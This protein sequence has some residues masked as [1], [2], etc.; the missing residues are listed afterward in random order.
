[1][2]RKIIQIDE[3]LCNGCGA[4]THVCAEAALEIV[5]GK[6]K[7]VRDFF[8][9]GMGACLD[10]CPVDA[11]KVVEKDTDAYDVEKTAEHVR[12]ARGEEAVK[13]VHGYQAEDE[14]E[15][16]GAPMACGCSGSMMRDFSDTPPPSPNN[17]EQTSAVS[18]LRQWPVQLH[19]VS[20]AAPYFK[21]ADLLISADCVPFA[22]ANFHNKFLKNKK[23]IMFCPKLDSGQE[24]YVEKL[25][26]LFQ[27][28]NIRSVTL[29]RMEV[30]C[31]GGVEYLVT[32][33]IKRAGVNVIIKDYTISIRGEVV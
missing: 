27:T 26:E 13:N 32:E 31:C 20:P 30:P 18:E 11:L 29:V 10:V 14:K 15:I 22:Y 4:C 12:K 8:C 25:T 23:L 2:K 7:L 6:A 28:Q 24:E 17:I 5:N 1:M 21:D 33:A 3:E 19:L 9:D 16:A